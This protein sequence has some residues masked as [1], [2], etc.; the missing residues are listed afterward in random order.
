MGSGPELVADRADGNQL[1]AAAAG[2]WLPWRRLQSEPGR[3]LLGALGSVLP[4]QMSVPAETLA[5]SH[6]FTASGTWLV[7]VVRA[8]VSVPGSGLHA[9]RSLW[10]MGKGTREVGLCGAQWESLAAVAPRQVRPQGPFTPLPTD[11]QLPRC[12]FLWSLKSDASLLASPMVLW[13]RLW[14]QLSSD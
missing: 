12:D 13:D 10:L 7:C 4:L 5:V 1:H 6:S 14:P 2:E 8:A 9:V 11:L 3:C